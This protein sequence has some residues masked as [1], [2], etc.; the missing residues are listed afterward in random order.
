MK[1]RAR[2]F[3]AGF[4]VFC[5][6]AS[7]AISQPVGSRPTGVGQAVMHDRTISLRDMPVIQP[8]IANREKEWEEIPNINLLLSW[9]RAGSPVPVEPGIDPA[10]QK[11]PGKLP[12]MGTLINMDGL[13]DA[14]NSVP[15][16]PNG[17]VS[18]DH[19]IQTVNTSFAI[20][21]KS[22]SLL[23]GPAMLRT[24]WEGLPYTSD[25]DPIVLFDHL[26]G[27]WMISQ[28]SLPNYPNGPF[29]ELIAISQTSD[30]LGSWYR[31]VFRFTRMP[32]Y[33][34]LGV[35]P[36][37]YYMSVNSF[38]SGS[39]NWIGPGAVVFERDSMLLGAPARMMVFQYGDSLSR[40]L[41]ADLD[42]LPPPAGSPGLFLSSID[43]SVAGGVDRLQIYALHA[44]WADSTASTFT[45]SA[46]LPT[47]PFDMN[48]C[49]GNRNC[50]PQ[51]GTNRKLDALSTQLMHRLQYRNFGSHQVLVTNQTVDVDGNNHAGIRWY[52]VRNAGS[53][54]TIHQQGTYA[55]DSAHRW[56]ASAAMDG[57]GNIALGYSMS[58]DSLYPSIYAT[59]RRASDPP[60]LMTFA[61]QVIIA[62]GG[63][64]SFPEG[65]WG[66]Y[67]MLAV[68]PAD[69]ATFWYTNEY[70][71]TSGQNNW[72]TRIASF[73]I[74]TLSDVEGDGEK[75]L[76]VSAELK[77]NYPNPFNPETVIGYSLSVGGY[78][79]INV[80]DVLGREV[81][82]LVDEAQS[83]GEHAVRWNPVAVA[84][85]VYYYRI[86]S[87]T[88][89]A[90][91][92]MLLIR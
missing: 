72:S 42:G 43:G 49:G 70:Y 22:G 7:V 62:G 38:A 41:P 61:E 84:G 26:A 15:P 12:A 64:Q 87:G 13:A 25:G 5:L 40:L 1:F 6:A 85:G 51:K 91:R 29:Y 53:G 28:F 80:Y 59:G 90:I 23:Y 71:A 39:G 83:A 86:Q 33:P 16:D 27:R 63:V 19:Y 92:K 14:V 69:D 17:D 82:K 47:A 31:Y 56:M 89:S 37:G 36:D 50:I 34:K 77:Q 67:S 32:D 18:D 54:W 81:A 60:G 58:G 9:E 46:V 30:P 3:V 10:L 21:S 4:L 8:G 20:W 35:W 73:N 48:M 55:P 74:T 68:D 45:E 24:I 57:A 65:R 11:S 79:K 76:P 75:L 2:S 66:D 52:E 88:W 44:D 78:V